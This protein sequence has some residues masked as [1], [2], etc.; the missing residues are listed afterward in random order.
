MRIKKVI[1]N[2]N[3]NRMRYIYWVVLLFVLL[4]LSCENEGLPDPFI[5]EDDVVMVDSSESLKELYAQDFLLG[6]SLNSDQTQNGLDAISE[7]LVLKHFNS[8]VAGNAMKSKYIQPSEGYFYFTEADN[9]MSFGESH[10]MAMIGHTLVWHSQVPDWI[11]TD[12]YG[13]DVSRELL[14]QRMKSHINTLVGRYKGS[15]KGW[16]VVNEA[17]DY[18]HLRETKWW[19]IIGA[20]YIDSAFA[21]TNRADP[22]AELY[23]N[24]FGLYK[25]AKRERTIQIIEDLQAAN[26]RI[27]AVGMQAHYH[28]DTPIEEVEKSIIAF[29]ELGVKVMITELDISVL[30]VPPST[31]IGNAEIGIDEE[32]DAIYDPYTE[33][34]PD[35]VDRQLAEKYRDLFAMFLKHSDK[36]SRVTFWGLND[37][38]SWKNNHPIKGRTDYPL[39]FDRENKLKSAFYELIK[40][41]AN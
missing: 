16:D 40:L 6:V 33:G 38:G 2:L 12:R 39:L 37:A 9:F 21:Y 30:P 20:D 17:V 27:D 7:Q 8:L 13:N 25:E 31:D 26:I 10:N 24:D 29:A 5:V 34:L 22:D 4:F 28:L 14:L 23:Y 11:F 1:N 36:I 15:V 3:N 35:D 18:N 19:S 41:K 32:Y